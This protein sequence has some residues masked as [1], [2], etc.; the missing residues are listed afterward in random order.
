MTYNKFNGLD[1]L[2]SDQ[3]G[4]DIFYC[5]Q[6]LENVSL[7]QMF[8][9]RS[10]LE[11]NRTPDL[12]IILE[13]NTDFN[14]GLYGNSRTSSTSTPTGPATPNAPITP[15]NGSSNLP[16]SGDALN[17][18]HAVLNDLLK[19]K[20]AEVVGTK[21]TNTLI[22]MPDG[23]T[24]EYPTNKLD[25]NIMMAANK[26]KGDNS[27]AD[28]GESRTSY[29]LRQFKAGKTPGAGFDA[30]KKNVTAQEQPGKF[31]KAANAVG[32]F[33]GK[34]GTSALNTGASTLRDS[35]EQSDEDVL[36][37]MGEIVRLAGIN[38]KN[39]NCAGSKSQM[40]SIIGNTS[41]SHKPSVKLGHE[42]R[43]ERVAK[44]RMKDNKFKKE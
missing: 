41:D 37:E 5:R 24:T 35:V 25:P 23:T 10:L 2:L 40:P 19:N 20:Q 16:S 26:S 32:K 22:R 21:G 27:P 33:A 30:R 44:E 14:P 31:M 11:S 4:V 29:I 42:L 3:T 12:N 13:A 15:A 18:D 28:N 1:A 38:G 8:V 36:E 17:N 43:K 34:V 39:E 7:A 9:I 6:L